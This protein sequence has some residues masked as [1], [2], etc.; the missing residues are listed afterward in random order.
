MPGWVNTPAKEKAWKKAKG[1][2]RKQR[3][4]VEDDFSDKDWGLVT[5]IAQNMLASTIDLHKDEA[6]TVLLAQ[7]EYLLEARR[8]KDKKRK[9]AGLPDDVRGLVEA[10]SA[11]MATGGQ[12]IAALRNMKKTGME[13]EAATSLA[14][15]L[16]KTA[17]TLKTLLEKVNGG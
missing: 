11:V 5:H 1:I 15:D 7:V 9:D 4:K 6:T 8:K 16:R 12:T 2:V 13:S 14:E 3:N 17:E 10:L